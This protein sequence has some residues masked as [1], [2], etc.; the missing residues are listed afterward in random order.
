MEGFAKF[1][2]VETKLFLR[3]KVAAIAVFGLP[4]ALVIG[5]GLIPGFGKPQKG[6]SGQIGTE[7]IASIGVAIVLATLGLNGV[8]M[9]ISQYRERGILRRL[10]VT[11]VRPLTLLLAKLVVWAAAAVASVIFLV[12]VTRFAFHVP[13]PRRLGWFTASF[14]LAIAALFALGM[15]AA[16]AAP[17]SRTAIGI[18]W[19]LFFPSMLLGGV[20]FP[21][22]E[23]SPGM[24]RAGE[25]TPLGSALHAVRDTWM[26][27]N[28]SPLYLGI[29]AGYAIVAGALAARFFRWDTGAA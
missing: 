8:P 16:A 17:T 24:R 19:L 7:F 22:E 12:V 29:M 14:L 3:E 15:L 23:M 1:A 25:F 18:G 27:L 9:V 20:Y 10:G 5:F 11:P 21:T 13:L 28:P 6:L 2:Y 26:G 4:I